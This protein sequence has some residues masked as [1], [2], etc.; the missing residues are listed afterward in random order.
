MNE[1]GVIYERVYIRRLL[2]YESPKKYYKEVDHM[3]KE[4]NEEGWCVRVAEVWE[5]TVYNESLYGHCAVC[6]EDKVFHRVEISKEDIV[7]AGYKKGEVVRIINGLYECV[8]EDLRK[9]MCECK[10]DECRSKS[11]VKPAKRS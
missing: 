7:S 6:K 9:E 5:D 11:I 4:G 3:Y 1:I 2:R 8:C 10:C